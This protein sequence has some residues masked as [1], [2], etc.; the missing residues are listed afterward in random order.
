MMMSDITL[1][2]RATPDYE[3]VHREPDAACKGHGAHESDIER[4]MQAAH[5]EKRRKDAQ[6]NELALGEIDD[7]G[8][9]CR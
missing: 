3:P 1:E 8:H 9:G 4:K 7:L 6:H 5:K 2:F